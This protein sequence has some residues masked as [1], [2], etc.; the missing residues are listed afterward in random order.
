MII[1]NIFLCFLLPAAYYK[2]SG[3]WEKQVIITSIYRNTTIY[4]GVFIAANILQKI[5]KV[6]IIE[7]MR[8]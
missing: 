6:N 2:V 7:I 3:E 5:L 8:I 1:N 4:T